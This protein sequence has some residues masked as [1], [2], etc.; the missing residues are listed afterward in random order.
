MP[1]RYDQ[2]LFNRALKNV[3]TAFNKEQCY[4][5]LI[6][7][8]TYNGQTSLTL[9]FKEGVN[10]KRIDKERVKAFS[11]DNKLRYYNY[12]VHLAAFCL[13]NYLKEGIS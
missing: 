11:K 12:N 1:M 10:P 13:P 5:Y 8:D 4:I 3:Q 7:T 9:S 2:T 6:P